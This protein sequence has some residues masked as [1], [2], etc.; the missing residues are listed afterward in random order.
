M[1]S[2]KNG[3]EY[4]KK[5]T[6]TLKNTSKD[7][8]DISEAEEYM[9]ESK[10]E[11][12]NFDSVKSD[13]IKDL[14]LAENPKSND[15]L[16]IAK[17][18]EM[19]F[20][21]FKN[22]GID[23]GRNFQLRIKIYDSLLILLDI[24]NKNIGYSRKNITYILVYNK[25]KRHTSKWYKEDKLEKE[26]VRGSHSRDLL[27]GRLSELAKVPYIQFDLEKY[28]KLYFKDVFTYST[29]QFQRNFV[30]KFDISYN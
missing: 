26:E 17:N 5:F 18:D 10:L 15:T 21:E 19:Y 14:Q 30:E 11:V 7:K 12:I 8:H 4:L 1:M 9:T 27:V 28:K 13:Y 29:I 16:F 2:N 22:G 20:I 6:D 25:E 24:L 3:I 23:I